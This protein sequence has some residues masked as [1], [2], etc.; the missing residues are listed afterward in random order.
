MPA[1]HRMVSD[2][3][4]YAHR[5]GKR[6]F[7][8]FTCERAVSFQP[9]LILLSALYLYRVLLRPKLGTRSCGLWWYFVRL[10]AYFSLVTPR[11]GD[12][13]V[14]VLRIFIKTI[15]TNCTELNSEQP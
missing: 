5:A 3:A 9:V 14:G 7:G 8:G 2:G 4:A 13:R 12:H 10:A 6:D 11:R 15:C 1:L